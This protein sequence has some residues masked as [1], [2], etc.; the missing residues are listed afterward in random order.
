MTS[1]SVARRVRR[2]LLAALA[3]VALA[4]DYDGSPDRYFS[5]FT[6]LT[7][8]AIGVWFLFA[9]V[10]PHRAD[11]WSMVRLALTMYGLLTFGV[12]WALLSPTDHPSGLLFLTNLGVHGVMPLAMAIEDLIAPWPRV[13]R[14]A[15]LVVVAWPLAY[16]MATIAR[17]EVTGWYPY[18]FLDEGHL[19]R[20]VVTFYIS[21]LLALFMG[22]A[23]LWRALVHRRHRRVSGLAQAGSE[24]GPVVAEADQPR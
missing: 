18:F 10:V 19:G 24:V 20:G 15:P 7:N 22:G 8:L 2:G 3:F 21:T 1:T 4:V 5:Y 13:N 12:Y 11:L 14:R 6:I 23:Y 16:T 9:A 17:G